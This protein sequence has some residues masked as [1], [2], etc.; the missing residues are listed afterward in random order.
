[1]HGAFILT[2][3]FY[4]NMILRKYASY[5]K[6]TDTISMRRPVIKFDT[7]RTSSI[8]LEANR[9]AKSLLPVTT[10]YVEKD[11]GAVCKVVFDLWDTR[12]TELDGKY[13]LASGARE[14]PRQ[15]MNVLE[16]SE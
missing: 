1:L 7:E 3:N 9:C 13:L 11:L 10:L 6:T 5:D 16:K 15:M 4:E 8:F 14:T 12:K 2:G